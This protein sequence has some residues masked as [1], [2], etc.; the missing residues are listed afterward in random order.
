[1]STTSTPCGLRLT[2]TLDHPREPA[3]ILG[4]PFPDVLPEACA[5]AEL[6]SRRDRPVLRRQAEVSFRDANELLAFGGVER[7]QARLVVE[8]V[9]EPL[10]WVRLEERAELDCA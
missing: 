3:G 10:H 5:S 2:K 8:P 9:Q 7:V 4:E 6:L 1:M